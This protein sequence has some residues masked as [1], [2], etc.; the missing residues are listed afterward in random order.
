[1]CETLTMVSHSLQFQCQLMVA[2]QLGFMSADWYG[3]CSGTCTDATP[4]AL[5]HDGS[6]SSWTRTCSGSQHP[7]KLRTAAGQDGSG[8]QFPLSVSEEAADSHLTAPRQITRSY[9]RYSSVDSSKYLSNGTSWSDGSNGLVTCT[10]GDQQP[11]G[12]S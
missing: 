11:I 10:R 5:R 8:A 1:M 4:A 7:D 2:R 6:D 9:C 12:R 3:K